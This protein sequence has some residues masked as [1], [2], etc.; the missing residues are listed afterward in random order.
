M[1]DKI[2]IGQSVFIFVTIYMFAYLCVDWVY[3]E[4]RDFSKMDEKMRDFEA[5]LNIEVLVLYSSILGAGFYTLLRGIK[6][7]P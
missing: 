1:S 7:L 5:W 6:S 3:R 4:E 2:R